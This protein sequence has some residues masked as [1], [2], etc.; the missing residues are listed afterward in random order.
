[1]SC[2]VKSLCH[3]VLTQCMTG[4]GKL[5]LNSLEEG[6]ELL[7]VIHVCKSKGVQ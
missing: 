4:N 5:L 2:N 3:F 6:A 7:N 1:M